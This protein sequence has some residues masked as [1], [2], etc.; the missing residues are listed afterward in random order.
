[1]VEKKQNISQYRGRLDRT[2]ASEELTNEESIKFLVKNQVLKS[3]ECQ[4]EVRTETVIEKKAK[5]V[6]S[7]IQ[8]LKS[9]SEYDDDIAQKKTPVH[10]D[11]K[12]KQ[13]TEECRVMYREGPEG[14][15][16]HTLLVEGYVDGTTDICL[17][18]S[19][20]INLYKKW[21]P[22][23]TVP[24][25]KILL[26]ECLQKVGTDEQISL[27]RMKVP[28][29][30]STREVVVRMFEFEYFKDGL[31]IVLFNSISDSDIVDT[32]THGFS[33]EM[34]PK[35]QDVTRIDVVGGFAIQ[36]VNE[37]RSYFRT[38]ANMDLKLEF[39]PPAFINFT[40]RQIIGSGFKLYQKKVALVSKGGD[41]DFTKALTHPIYNRVRESL[42]SKIKEPESFPME[43]VTE[44]AEPI[45][46]NEFQSLSEDI[47]IIPDQKFTTE[48]QE[49]EEE[50]EVI[51]TSN[52][53]EHVKQ[54][55]SFNGVNRIQISPEVK[56]ALETLEQAIFVVRQNGKQN[57]KVQS[58]SGFH[59]EEC[60]D[61]IQAQVVVEEDDSKPLQDPQ[62]SSNDGVSVEEPKIEKISLEPR[63]NSLSRVV[64]EEDVQLPYDSQRSNDEE[65]TGVE[66]SLSRNKENDKMGSG[67]WNDM[68]KIVP[69]K[70]KNKNKKTRLCC[71]HFISQD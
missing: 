53:K 3:I 33:Q 42:Y 40:S 10:G 16:L 60:F 43:E 64:P 11:W 26:T 38:I 50:L 44:M 19:W 15:P 22:Q 35:A 6:S 20:E 4:N 45:L 69:P 8:M 66:Y 23:F 36:K 1:M 7:F 70:R 13:D 65:K 46:E 71:F 48:I 24:T 31:I 68:E 9:A 39:V 54:R 55:I 29:P 58:F 59:N 57:S 47:T 5:E 17:C 41:E 51:E 18:L 14:T 12:I 67:N 49:I 2:L 61:L 32:S 63:S 25:F 30:L 27:V 34:I 56:Q 37:E 21:W 28:W 62:V 52:F